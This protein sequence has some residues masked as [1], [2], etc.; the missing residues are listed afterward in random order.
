MRMIIHA[1]LGSEFISLREEEYEEKIPSFCQRE[2][3]MGMAIT[4]RR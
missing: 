3:I 4:D 2:A 1:T